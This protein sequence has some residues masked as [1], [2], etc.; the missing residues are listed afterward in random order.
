MIIKNVIY[1][2]IERLMS[3]KRINP[4]TLAEK[5]ETPK[6]TMYEK[7][8]GRSKISVQLAISIKEILDT[9]MPLEVLFRQDGVPAA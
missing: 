3:E 5:T 1:L 4:V 8:A 7:L 9:D 2:E 6:T